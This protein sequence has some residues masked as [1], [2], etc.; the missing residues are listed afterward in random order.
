MER[1]RINSTIGKLPVLVGVDSY[2]AEMENVEI[3]NIFFINFN[4][5]VSLK[6]QR[7]VL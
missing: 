2:S 7:K 3:S 4:F 1:C 5:I 6:G